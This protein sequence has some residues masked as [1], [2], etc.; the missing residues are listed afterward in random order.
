[1]EKKCTK[2]KEVKTITEFNFDKSTKDGY[3]YNCRECKSIRYKKYRETSSHLRKVKLKNKI[4]NKE[5]K[6]AQIKENQEKLKLKYLNLEFGSFI[7][8]KF[9]GYFKNK[10]YNYKRYYFEKECKFCGVTSKA[11]PS[12]LETQFKNKI[13]C[14]LCKETVNIKKQ[15]KKCASCHTWY[16]ANTIYFPGSKNKPFGVHYYCRTCHKQKNRNR[17]LCPN[18]RKKE[19]HQKLKRL[20]EDELFRFRC[21]VTCNIKNSLLSNGYRKN[22]KSEKI[23]QCTHAEFR[24]YLENNFQEGMTWENHGEWHLDHQIPTSLAESYEEIISLCHYSNYQPMWSGENL[25]KNNKVFFN[26]ISE[27]NKIRY[28]EILCRAKNKSLLY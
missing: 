9:L 20:N 12:M 24:V 14:N 2:C 23:L 3:G 10:E 26:T 27:E 25:A 8:T 6:E 18:V 16:P 1:M 28:A 22:Q 11:T 7:V 21:R 15:E 17:R 19:Y 4:K 13:K 5:I